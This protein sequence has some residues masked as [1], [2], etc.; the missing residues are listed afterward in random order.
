MDSILLSTSIKFKKNALFKLIIVCL[1][2]PVLLI[3][4]VKISYGYII[5]LQPL[6]QSIVVREFTN[7]RFSGCNPPL[8]ATGTDYAQ[9]SGVSQDNVTWN[10][11]GASIS[12]ATSKTYEEGNIVSDVLIELT[13]WNTY[14]TSSAWIESDYTI[15]GEYL[16]N[17]TSDNNTSTKAVTT[18]W[19]YSYSIYEPRFSLYDASSNL[20]AGQLFSSNSGPVDLILNEN[21]YIKYSIYIDR[22]YP[23]E[24]NQKIGF[25]IAEAPPIPEP[26]T[27][28]LVGTGLMTLAAVGR[29]RRNQRAAHL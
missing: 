9:F 2:F 10:T 27:I 25:S 28:V 24:L 3:I 20:I 19:T 18:D 6:E 16:L 7:C 23:F 8:L 4:S 22:G 13:E 17:I 14:D 12:S 1:I 21:Y 15:K 29:K 11:A 5:T 26:A